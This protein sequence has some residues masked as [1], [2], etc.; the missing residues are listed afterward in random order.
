MTYKCPHCNK[1]IGF[2]PTEDLNGKKL[3]LPDCPYRKRR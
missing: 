2:M 3:R 1:T